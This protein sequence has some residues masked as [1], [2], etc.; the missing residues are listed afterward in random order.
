MLVKVRCLVNQMR[1]DSLLLNISR[2]F[3]NYITCGLK[4]ITDKPGEPEGPL[5]VSDV[6]KDSAVLKWKPPK[7]DGGEPVTHYVLE[8]MDTARGTWVDAGETSGPECKFKV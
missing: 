4:Y 7:D 3:F 1:T 8:K 2:L 5:D 6:K